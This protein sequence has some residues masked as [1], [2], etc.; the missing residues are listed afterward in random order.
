MSAFATP[1]TPVP[2]PDNI[3]LTE[4]VDKYFTAYNSARLREICQ[5]LSQ[6]VFQ[7]R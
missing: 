3:S 5:L 1:I 7:H 4:L 2:I 6:R